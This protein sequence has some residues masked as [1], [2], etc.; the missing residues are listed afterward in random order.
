MEKKETPHLGS[1]GINSPGFATRKG[2]KE[3]EEAE[4]WTKDY[5]AKMFAHMEA[6]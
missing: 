5:W 3:Y 6:E 1:M 2:T 4:Q